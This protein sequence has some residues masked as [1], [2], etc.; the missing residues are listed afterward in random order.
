M[1]QPL[2]K[3]QPLFHSDKVTHLPS[4]THSLTT[5]V[6]FA[7]PF[8]YACSLFRLSGDHYHKVPKLS[9]TSAKNAFPP[10][11]P[12]PWPETPF[13]QT[14]Q[15]LGQKC[16]FLKLSK[17][18]AKYTLPPNF[19]RP[20]PKTFFTQTFQ[21]LGQTC[22][23]LKLSKTLAKNAF[24]LN[25]PRPWPKTPFRQT[26]Q[27][28][29]KKIF[30]PKH[31]RPGRRHFNFPKHFPNSETPHGPC[32]MHNLIRIIICISSTV[33]VRC[34]PVCVVLRTGL[35][36]CESFYASYKFSFIH[37]FPGLKE[38]TSVFRNTSQILKHHTDPV[39]HISSSI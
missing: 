35:V 26:F 29:A 22:L 39:K 19:P 2:K 3:Q 16:L 37:S 1:H 6:S 34:S 30:F 32:Q 7:L 11:F 23:F 5:Q 27:D 25:F 20:W 24:P 10:N 13:P 38:G 18:L 12:R 31:S 8:F 14:F 17:T 9:K 15:E 33:Y 28:L 21:E 4:V 36:L